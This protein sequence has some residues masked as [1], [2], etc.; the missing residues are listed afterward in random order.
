MSRPVEPI[1]PESILRAARH[2]FLQ[3]GYSG[4]STA[5]LALDLGITKAALY[6]HFPDK[7]A[8]FLAMV[9]EYLD[10][11]AA[12]LSSLPP[13]F[14]ANDREAALGSLAEVFLSR[15]DTCV[16]IQHLSLQESRHL[17]D[18]GQAALGSIYHDAM[19]RPVSDLLDR[20]AD[21]GWLRAAAEGE[22]PLIW[23]FLALLSAYV[24][25]GHETQAPAVPPTA[26]FIRL[27]LGGL[28]PERNTAS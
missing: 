20:A 19:V 2:R 4:T 21:R 25:L 22:P 23:T 15:I 8:L 17:S 5:R 7:E 3:W 28:A 27:L 9:R 24:P 18:A 26:S 1:G 12:E 10:E 16:R 14:E 6:Y 11:V 13:V